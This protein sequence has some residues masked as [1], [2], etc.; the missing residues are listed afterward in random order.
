ML[1]HLMDDVGFVLTSI[2]IGTLWSLLCYYWGRAD[3]KVKEQAFREQEA[4]GK[5]RAKRRLPDY[6][7][8]VKED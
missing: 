4:L 1:G 5:W 6:L 2:V 7:K 8:L 3:Q